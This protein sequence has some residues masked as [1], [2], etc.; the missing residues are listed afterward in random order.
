MFTN[1][2]EIKIDGLQSMIEK[3]DLSSFEKRFKLKLIFLKR[4]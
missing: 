3:R 1:I 4:D 2:V